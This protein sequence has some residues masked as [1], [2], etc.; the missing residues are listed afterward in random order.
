MTIDLDDRQVFVNASRD[1]ADTVRITYDAM[2]EKGLPEEVCIQISVEWYR[3]IQT[4]SS[5]QG[6]QEKTIELLGKL[7]AEEG[8][9]QG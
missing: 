5:Q 7:F 1:I 4:Q 8:E 9:E 3:I 6:L 2:R